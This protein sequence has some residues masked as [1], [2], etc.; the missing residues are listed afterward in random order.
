[1]VARVGNALPAY[2]HEFVSYPDS[3]RLLKQWDGD[4]RTEK[5]VSVTAAYLIYTIE[6]ESLTCFALRTRSRPGL[7]FNGL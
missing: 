4:E 6:F 1:M 5:I 2:E 7:L 3:V